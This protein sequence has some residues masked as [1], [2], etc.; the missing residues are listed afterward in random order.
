[1]SKLQKARDELSQAVAEKIALNDL[2]NRQDDEDDLIEYKG[3]KLKRML[4]P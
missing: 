3:K 4:P 1:L 2:S